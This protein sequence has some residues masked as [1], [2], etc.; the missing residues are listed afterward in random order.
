[1]TTEIHKKIYTVSELNQKIRMLLEGDIGEIWCEGEIS[2]YK[3]YPSGHAY[4]SL[5]DASAQLKA[6]MFRSAREKIQFEPK[7]GLKV[8]AH[9]LISYY[10]VRGDCQINVDALEPSGLGAL[11][12]AFQ[13]LKEKLEKEGLFDSRRKK[14]IPALPQRIGIITSQTGAA[15]RDILSVLS[16]RFANVEVLL[17]PVRVQGTE[18]K[19]EIAQAIE[20]MNENFPE[21][22]VLL[23]G[24]GGGSLEDLWAFNEEIVA[25]AIAASRIPIISCVGHEIDYT[26]ADFVADLRAP[27]PSAAAEL[28]V[29]NKAEI[30][31]RIESL[32]GRLKQRIFSLLETHGARLEQIQKSRALTRPAQIFEERLQEMDEFRERIA[33]AMVTLL[34]LVR[35]SLSSQAEK[36]GILSPLAHLARGYA[37]AWK[38]PEN[39]ILKDSRR[40]K[41]RDSVKI[42]LHRGEVFC[43][44]EK[45]T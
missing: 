43:T 38:L 2:N 20:E 4:F 7:D 44:V 5:K 13:Q 1:M 40:L 3:L 25:R 33:R 42:R 9:G 6:V 31:Q 29:K 32:T 22:D 34:A 17:Y 24:R 27:T 14:R 15:I 23:V 10:T 37:I 28:V 35:S 21:L 26:I 12:L 19:T 41:P 11:M 45:T 16:R 30:T 39:E 36:L 8:V 18:A